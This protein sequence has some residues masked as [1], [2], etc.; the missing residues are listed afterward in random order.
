[1]EDRQPV[2]RDKA[3]PVKVYL[4]PTERAGLEEKAAA[5]GL[6]IAVYLRNVG[7]GIAVPSILDHKAVLALLKVN[8]D[9]GRLGGLLKLWLSGGRAGAPATETRRLLYDIEATQKT[10]RGIVDRL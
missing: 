6:P 7:L 9:L 10:L 2:R 5:T 8:A 1:M 4:S 3:K